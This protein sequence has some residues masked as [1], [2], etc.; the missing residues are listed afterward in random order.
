L[1]KIQIGTS[2]IEA[3]QIALGCMRMAGLSLNDASS[4]VNSARE[5]EINF[6]DHADIYGSGESEITF[7]KVIKSN[8][9]SR[10]D[11]FI[12]SK[13]GIR[14]GFYDFSKEHIMSSVEGSLSRLGTD[15]LDVLA[16]HRPDALMEPDEVAEAFYQLHKQ[17]KVR[18]FGVSNFSPTSLQLLQ[19][20]LTQKLEVNQLQFGLKH[21]GMVASNM[22][23]NMENDEGINRDGAVLDHMRLNNITI[24]A[25]SPYQYGYFEGVFV[26]HPKFKK[27]N[28]VLDRLAVEYGVTSTG[29]AIAWINRHPANI[30]TIIGTMN[31]ERIK[32]ISQASNVVLTR[33]QWYELYKTSGFKL[34]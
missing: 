11:I 8:T 4:V 19:Q 2:T 16:L 29:I 31:A 34:L 24:Q 14:E 23:V 12:Q 9:I 6:F 5:S 21:A 7:G 20:A 25:W 22:N 13:C 27:L 30:Q 3:S 10:T 33:Q 15:Y 18:N 26:D 28:E 17:G 32:E 1:K